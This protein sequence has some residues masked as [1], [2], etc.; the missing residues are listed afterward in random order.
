MMRVVNRDMRYG[1]RNRVV[2]QRRKLYRRFNAAETRG[3]IGGELYGAFQAGDKLLLQWLPFAGRGCRPPQRR[4]GDQE[5]R[6]AATAFQKPRLPKNKMGH[7]LHD[8]VRR[9]WHAQLRLRGGQ[10]VEYAG[11]WQVGNGKQ[12]QFLAVHAR[13]LARPALRRNPRGPLLL[14]F[15]VNQRRTS[16]D[17]TRPLP[18]FTEQANR[19]RV[20]FRP[21][22]PMTVP[23]TQSLR[24]GLLSGSILSKLTKR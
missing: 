4:L 17:R 3:F 8:R 2:R 11:R 1:I 16:T 12:Q 7:D 5:R 20:A 13:M 22:W 24:P 21:R 6:H 23:T 19:S 14:R 15:R 10:T 18:K 9:A